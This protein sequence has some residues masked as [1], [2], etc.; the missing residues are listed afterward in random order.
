RSALGARQAAEV[1]VRGWW[2]WWGCGSGPVG[3]RSQRSRQG[4]GRRDQPMLAGR[5]WPDDAGRVTG[6]PTGTP[7]P[8]QTGGHTHAGPRRA[9]PRTAPPGPPGE[10]AQRR[11]VTAGDVLRPRGRCRERIGERVLHAV[12]HQKDVRTGERGDVVPRSVHD[13]AVEPER[14]PGRAGE[15][16]DAVPLRHPGDRFFAGHTH[17]LLLQ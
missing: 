10:S 8:G 2:G 9:G 14:R 1:S 15:L 12:E 5:C 13:V 7:T 17:S 16:V 4:R 6:P 3:R 11:E